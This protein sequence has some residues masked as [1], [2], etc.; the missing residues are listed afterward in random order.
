MSY[1]RITIVGG[2][3][4]PGVGGIFLSTVNRAGRIAAVAALLAATTLLFSSCGRDGNPAGNTDADKYGS[5]AIRANVGGDNQLW[6][7]KTSAALKTEPPTKLIIQVTASDFDTIRVESVINPNQPSIIDTVAKIPPGKNRRVNIRAV[8]KN[9]ATTHID[10]VETRTVE[11]VKNT[12]TPVHAILLPAKGSIYLMFNDLPPTVDSVWAT[13]KKSD[14]SL[15]AS[16]RVGAA[17]KGYISLDNIPHLT[18]GTLQVD[19]VS[20]TGEILYIA[21]KEHTFNARGDNNI[22]LHF[23]TVGGSVTVDFVRR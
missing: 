9:G 23:N 10:S 6:L 16:N 18:T 13:F 17:I 15:V 4:N 21:T 8:D 2:A 5:I 7:S 19:I 14:G 1:H 3:G 22:D 20:Y 11:I 12:V